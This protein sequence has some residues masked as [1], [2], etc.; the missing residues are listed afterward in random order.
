[1]R[2]S[3]EFQK[4][5]T[6][7]FLTILFSFFYALS[8]FFFP[9]LSIVQKIV[10]T[11][12]QIF[13]VYIWSA[14]QL[15]TL[16]SY[17][18]YVVSKKVIRYVFLVYTLLVLLSI[19]FG[20]LYVFHIVPLVTQTLFNTFSSLLILMATGLFSLIL[21]LAHKQFK[22]QI[23]P[24]EPETQVVEEKPKET[25]KPR[26]KQFKVGTMVLTVF[27]VL[28]CLSLMGIREYKLSGLAFWMACIT[29]GIR[30]RWN[31]IRFQKAPTHLMWF[32]VTYSSVLGFYGALWDWFTGFMFYLC[33]FIILI[34]TNS[35]QTESVMRWIV[36]VFSLFFA[37]ICLLFHFLFSL[38]YY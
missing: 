12:G 7:I 23:P 16:I 35:Y 20:L 37:F 10:G 21:A 26:T 31:T 38:R 18:K 22:D 25:Y 1:M 24:F 6:V 17:Y 8:A 9:Q 36:L 2:R 3:E 33:N 5:T 11:S 15:L 14:A 13:M 32:L 19:I 27:L 29:L 30:A 28:V 34:V 4:R